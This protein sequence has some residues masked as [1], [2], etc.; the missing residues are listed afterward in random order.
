MYPT[1]A[2]RH[3]FNETDSDVNKEAISAVNQGMLPLLCIG[4][5]KEERDADEYYNLVI[6]LFKKD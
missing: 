1:S 2:R 3:V 6:Q 4:E 5:T